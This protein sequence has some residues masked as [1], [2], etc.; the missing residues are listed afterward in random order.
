[1]N[2]V[3]LIIKKR[4]GGKL[5]KDEI[6]FFVSGVVDSSIPDYQTSAMLMAIYFQNLDSEETSDLTMAMA[7]SGD[8]FDLSSVEGIK[9]DKHPPAEWPTLPPLYLLRLWQAAECPL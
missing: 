5:T 2:I 6:E 1:M 9:V 7:N 4:D 8:T 3:D